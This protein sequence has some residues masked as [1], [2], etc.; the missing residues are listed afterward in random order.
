MAELSQAAQDDLDAILDYTL[1][2]YGQDQ[3]ERYY[4]GLS[5]AF[6]A[7]DDNP[8]LARERPEFNPPG[9]RILPHAHHLI[10]YLIKQAGGVLVVRVLHERMDPGDHFH[11]G[12]P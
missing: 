10:V 12:T 7:L 9:I 8:R 1:G 5:E 4:R 6:H 11:S 3:A 2:I